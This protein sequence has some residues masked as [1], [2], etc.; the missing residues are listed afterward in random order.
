MGSRCENQPELPG[1]F[2]TKTPERKLRFGNT[3][4]WMMPDRQLGTPEE[5]AD[6]LQLPP[7]TLAEWRSRGLGPKYHK[8]GRHVRYRWTDVEK[9]LDAQGTE[10]VV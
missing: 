6:Y 10:A 2:K 5:V 1:C 7:K 4:R 8:V 3:R 9:W